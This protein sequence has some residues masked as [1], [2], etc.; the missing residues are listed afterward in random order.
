MYHDSSD[1]EYRGL[2][3]SFIPHSQVIAGH[4]AKFLHVH[5]I[6][7]TAAHCAK[8]LHVSLLQ[9]RTVPNLE[10]SLK[11]DPHFLSLS[12]SFSSSFWDLDLSFCSFFG[13]TSTDDDDRDCSH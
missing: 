11:K 4:C 1:L 12:N 13:C 5:C 9:R 10:Y 8:F 3:I 2:V 6:I 7:A